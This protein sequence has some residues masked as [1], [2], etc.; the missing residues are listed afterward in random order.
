MSANNPTGD[1]RLTLENIDKYK[2]FIDRSDLYYAVQ[3]FLSALDSAE[4]VY[5]VSQF[6]WLKELPSY[7]T[8][9]AV[10]SE[11]AGEVEP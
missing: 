3:N 6:A 11:I 8:L 1:F 2:V 10:L 9:C 7:K 4:Q 5:Q